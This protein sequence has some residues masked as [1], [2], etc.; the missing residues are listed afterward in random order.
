DALGRT[1]SYQYDKAGN[2]T[3][4]TDARAKASQ[5]AYDAMNRLTQITNPVGGMFKLQYNGQ[6]LPIQV[7]DEDGRSRQIEFD[8]FLR[9]TKQLDG[10][11]NV[12]EYSYNIPDGSGNGTLGALHSP[13]EIKYPTF[14]E[15]Q[16][17]DQR[18]RP[19][20]QTLL[21][22]NAL[23]TDNLV[24]GTEYDKRG[25]IRSQ[26]DANGKASGNTY[27]AF[28]Q[29]I[30]TTD[31]LGHKTS[32]QYDARGNLLQLT[33]AN[34]HATRFEYD[35]ANRLVKEILPLGQTT[36]Y[37]Y[38]EAGNLTQR[39]DPNGNQH[40]HTYDAVNRQTES[41]QT[42]A[43]GTLTRTLAYTWDANGNLTAWSD[44]DHSRNQTS[45]ATLTFDA[46]NRKTGETVT[47]PNGTT[48]GYGAAYSPAGKQTQL[49]WPDGTQIGYGYSAH[50][51]LE[52]VTIPGEGTISVNPFKWTVPAKITLP[53][54]SV[55]EKSYDGLLNLESL[56]AKT[57][58]QQ[59]VLSLQNSYGKL[60]ELKQSKRTDSMDGGSSSKDSNYSYDA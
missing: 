44:T 55:Q 30:E 13:V 43:Q 20:S 12:T 27:N 51:E 33:D 1:R 48:L 26:T 25:R 21:N 37:R 2:L 35:K 34:G 29:R 59:T 7:S 58:G 47:W 53:G 18:E 54:G 19:T 17:Y 46:A 56:K 14:T 49:T 22:P 38:D 16:R 50:G 3:R 57:P 45:S 4:Y 5:A 23:G 39:T 32:Y 6:G 9:I 60:L 42:N 24:S 41:K 28:E 36:V 40:A 11:G 15:R 10:L 52:S 31:R 8:N